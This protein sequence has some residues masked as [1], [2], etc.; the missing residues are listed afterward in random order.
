LVVTGTWIF[1]EEGY[2]MSSNVGTLWYSFDTRTMIETAIN[3]GM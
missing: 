2:R 1:P 3:R